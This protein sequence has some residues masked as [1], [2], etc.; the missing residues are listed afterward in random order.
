L[1]ALAD[2]SDQHHRRSR[3]DLEAIQGTGVQIA[4]SYATLCECYTL[5]LRRLGG[6]YARI[7]LADVFAGAI[8]VNPE[9]A[10]YADGAAELDR[11]PD[12]PITLVDAVTASLA[13]RLKSLVWT[14]DRHFD[15]L[16]ADI[17]HRNRLG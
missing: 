8:L 12:Q 1:Y 13:R 5:I 3:S 2:P 6:G 9:P 11:F 7:W 15:I 10:D 17:W 4:V 16:R 14:F